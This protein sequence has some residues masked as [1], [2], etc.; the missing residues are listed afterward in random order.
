MLASVSRRTR[1]RGAAGDDP[2]AEMSESRNAMAVV[3]L[4]V[5]APGMKGDLVVAMLFRLR[6]LR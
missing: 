6:V 3:V 5:T 2:V 1:V 4:T